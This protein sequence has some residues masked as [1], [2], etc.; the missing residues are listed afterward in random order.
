[1][2]NTFILIIVM[3]VGGK[4]LRPAVI[5]QEFN[6]YTACE[7]ARVA[8]DKAIDPEE[9]IHIRLHGCFAKGDYK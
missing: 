9:G 4:S 2:I 3:S 5:Q 8:I 1:M 7:R 6:S